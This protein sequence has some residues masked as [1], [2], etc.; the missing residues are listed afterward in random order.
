MCVAGL[1]RAPASLGWFR[2]GRG[3][4]VSSLCSPPGS[5]GPPGQLLQTGCDSRCQIIFPLPR[6]ELQRSPLPAPEERRAVRRVRG[7][8]KWGAV[9]NG[10]PPRGRH[11]PL[12]LSPGKEQIFPSFQV[13]KIPRSALCYKQC[14]TC[15]LLAPPDPPD[16]IHIYILFIVD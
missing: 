4:Q 16:C 10:W 3:E 12:P 2:P 14:T 11:F 8:A 7:P 13:R 9:M 5:W 1:D 6:T 15:F